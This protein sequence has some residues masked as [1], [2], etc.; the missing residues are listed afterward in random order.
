MILNFESL[1]YMSTRI[2]VIQ[3]IY[4]KEIGLR[5]IMS[6]QCK[7]LYSK[8]NKMLEDSMTEKAKQWLDTSEY[9]FE[10][11]YFQLPM[12]K[13]HFVDEGEGEPIIFLHGNPGWS[14]EYRNAIK[15]FSKTN[16]CIAPDHIGFG[17]SDKPYDWDYLP[18]HHAKNFESLMNSLDLNEITLVVNDWGGPIGLSYAI[19][20]PERIKKLLILNTWMWSAENDPYYRKF[21]GFMGGPIGRFLIR[22]FNFF[23]KVIIK[24]VVGNKKLSKHVHEHLYNHL[25]TK[26]DRKGCW[27]FPKQI[28]ASSEWLDSLWQQ[29]DKIKDIP[30][31]ILWGMKDIAFREQELKVWEDLMT[32]K[33]VLRLEEVGHYPQEEATE[34]FIK[35]LK[36]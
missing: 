34:I 2:G 25:E 30:T 24:Q 6:N 26:K 22:N 28:I 36:E 35:E 23:G 9:P 11:N 31:T 15:K 14:F 8:R 13:M 7:I 10:K 3:C 1:A 16:R 27:T 21:S 5:N 32:N 18:K 12:G 20:S 33:K 4:C 19:R 29:R 17:L